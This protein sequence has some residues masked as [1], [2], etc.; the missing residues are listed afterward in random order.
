MKIKEVEL[1]ETGPLLVPIIDSKHYERVSKELGV[2][3]K[4]Y[5]EFKKEFRKYLNILCQDLTIRLKLD[6]GGVIYIKLKRGFS[7]DFAS[8]PEW[9]RG[10][11][12]SN[13]K[14]MIIPA[15]IHDALFDC[16]TFSFSQSNKFYYQLMRLYK[17]GWWRS[18]FYYWGVC[19]DIARN[20]FEE[21]KR[22]NFCSIDWRS[23]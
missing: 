22:G 19:T 5:F 4:P 23:K 6:K 15:L 16:K 8:V 13:D 14:N 2:E 21:G 7:F 9:L 18:K 20:R 3:L 17:N 1:M 10:R 11:F 12:P